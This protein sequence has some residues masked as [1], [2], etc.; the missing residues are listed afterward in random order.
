MSEEHG[1]SE[2]FSGASLEFILSKSRTQ[3]DGTV[4]MSWEVISQTR[5]FLRAIMSQ[6]L[7]IASQLSSS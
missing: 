2:D 1:R 6:G 3:W 4:E 7:V 5:S